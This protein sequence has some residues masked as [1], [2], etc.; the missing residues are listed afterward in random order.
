VRPRR[1]A[2][3]VAPDAEEFLADVRRGL[4]AARKSL[5]CKWFY[6]EEGSRLFDAICELSEYYPTRTELSILE[7][8]V[9]EMT[10]RIGPEAVLVEYGSGSSVKTELLLDRLERAAA[11][12]PIEISREH[13]LGTVA[14]LHERYPE[15]RIVPV[16][17]DYTVDIDLPSSV[18]TGRRTAFFPGSTI[19]NFEPEAARAFL[20]RIRHVVGSGGGLLIG[21]D[22]K[23]DRAVLEAAYDDAPGVTRD[24]NRNLLV[25]M[26]RELG[27]DFDPD[28]FRHRAVW[29]EDAGRVEM[30]LEST[31]DQTVTIRGDAFAFRQGETIWTESS[32]KYTR[33]GFANLAAAAGFT[34]DDVWTDPREWFSVQYLTAR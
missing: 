23:K 18:P 25:R 26:N 31:R 6:D 10:A 4:G 13:L 3:D 27:A 15:L 20:K 7:K 1:A 22:L 2:V 19:G 11:Y 28:A 9:G 32:Y 24:F 34:V 30:H 5:P 33:E 29:N 12:V 14:R 17:A 16:V 21:V 8:R